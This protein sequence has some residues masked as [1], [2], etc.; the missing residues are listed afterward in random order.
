MGIFSVK[1]LAHDSLLI[2]MFTYF[3]SKG[4]S[5]EKL[6]KYGGVCKNIDLIFYKYNHQGYFEAFSSFKYAM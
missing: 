1:S 4:F 3:Q 5:Q 2:E 6:L